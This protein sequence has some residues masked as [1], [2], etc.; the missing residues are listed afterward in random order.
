MMRVAIIGFLAGI[1]LLQTQAALDSV[2]WWPLAAMPLPVLW[3][4]RQA[5]PPRVQAFARPIFLGLGT[6]F[7]G[8]A[9]ASWRAET[10]L[11]AELPREWESRDVT[12]TGL[13]ANLPQRTDRGVRF[14]F[15]VES[16]AT[17]GAVVPTL[18]LLSWYDE[19]DRKRG[20]TNAAPNVIP[21]ERWTLTVRLKR[22]HGTQNPHGFD[23]E[24]W[25]LERSIRATGYVRIKGVNER[26]VENLGRIDTTI[27]RARMALRDAMLKSL[28]GKPY[29][30]ILVALAIGQQNAISAEQWREFW[31]TGTGHLM[32]IS[33]LHITMVA[34]MMAWLTFH[35]WARIPLLAARIPA[36]R[37]AAVA[38]ACAALGYS[39][40]AG[41][42]VPTQRT[43]FMLATVAFFLAL[44]RGISGSRILATALF[45][46]VL[47]DP[48]AVMAPGFW[49]SF[50]AVALIFLA[51][52]HRTG[53][54]GSLSAALRT[55]AAV[56][57]G[58]LPLTLILFQE[59][60]L[61]SPAANAIA[62]PLVSLVVVPLALAGTIWQMLFDSGLLLHLAHGCMEA[63]YV[64]LN[65]MASFDHAVWQSHAPT[66]WA[67]ALGIVAAVW[68]LLPRG[69]PGRWA[70]AILLVPLVAV[71]PPSPAPGTFWAHVLD[72]GQGL[73]AV[74][75]TEKHALV[76]DAGPSWNPDAD[77]GNRIVVPFLRGEGIRKLDTLIVSHADD[78][79][80][81][82]A[83]SIIAARS[84]S[85]VMTSM[86]A[87]APQVSAAGEIMKC[88][89]G[90]TWR[91]DG[92]DFD[93]L[94]PSADDYEREGIKSN[95]MGCVLKVSAGGKSVLLTA[96]IEKL[97]EQAILSRHADDMGTLKSTLLV[98]PHH[99]S[100][101]SSTEA[102]LDAVA[103]E[104]AILPVGYRNRFRHPNAQVM[105]RYAARK[106][107]VHRT[108]TSGAITVRVSP[109]GA[110][111]V[112]HFRTQRSRYW[113][114]APD[115]ANE[116]A[117]P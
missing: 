28:D 25:A 87:E 10:R 58:L 99:G 81:G 100:R 24:A 112:E 76:F 36:Q 101:T 113:I 19:V 89:A 56:T 40:I 70:A 49:L 66:M 2:W 84:P 55:Q 31:R 11:A 114:E 85:W 111:R 13:V 71:T 8:F 20:E 115:V 59:V 107:P 69:M 88:E 108:D 15:E 64:I 74:V 27:H 78:D 53:A 91:W 37:A 33:G 42:S 18:L 3:L 22:P 96:D 80:S 23:F 21:G 65:W 44:G 72:V 92:V 30:G 75:R 52:S 48:W 104:M 41:F 82:G 5:G 4:F 61:I 106:I 1:G 14:E 83:S 26:Q 29:A 63:C 62:I 90:D 98:V 51:T 68:L 12:F 9:F 97:A 109:D 35:L 32:S 110:P 7:L 16:V 50:G 73:A 38:G 39:L 43:F 105:Q 95:N 47:I 79:H 17:T 67:G 54:A 46:V 116:A 57:I 93:I 34:S 103:P 77:S 94:H 117:A 60:S 6:A 102:F 86:S 45:V